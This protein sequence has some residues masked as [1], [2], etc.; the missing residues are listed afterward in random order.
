MWIA[1]RSANWTRRLLKSESPV[2]KSASG[3]SRTKVAK[4]AAISRLV[5]ALE[6]LNSQ[7]HDA[8]G[9][10]QFTQRDIGSRVVWISKHS[11]A[12]RSGHQFSQE[13]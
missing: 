3:R 7:S 13:F 10:L 4:A 8:G 2:T 6:N 5:L 1:A 11:H 9:Y 12:N